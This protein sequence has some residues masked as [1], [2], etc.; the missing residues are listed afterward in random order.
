[1]YVETWGGG[2]EGGQVNNY[3][4][5]FWVTSSGTDFYHA[6]TSV[7]TV[8]ILSQGDYLWL[9]SVPVRL[10]RSFQKNGLQKTNKATACS[11]ER[12]QGE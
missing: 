10:D 6:T 2:G 9:F 11:E 5:H 1:M 3:K 8:H 12:Q 4:I 7:K